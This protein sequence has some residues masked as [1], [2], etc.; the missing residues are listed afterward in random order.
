M[1][2]SMEDGNSFTN[3]FCN[4]VDIIESK[5]LDSA[6][7]QELVSQLFARVASNGDGTELKRL[8]EG[9]EGEKWIDIDYRD[10]EGST[11][12]ICASCFGH[13]HVAELLLGYGAS[14][15]TQDN[16]GWTA[17]MW[18]TSNQNEELVRILLEHGASSLAKSARGHTAMNIAASSN[19]S[20]GGSSD[21][22]SSGH[23]TPSV[24]STHEEEGTDPLRADG[25]SVGSPRSVL[26]A[27]R[28]T[29]SSTATSKRA[30]HARDS[31]AMSGHN[32]LSMLQASSGANSQSRSRDNY[33]Q[34]QQPLPTGDE[35]VTALAGK[36]RELANIDQHQ[37]QQFTK[38]G[39]LATSASSTGDADA[40]TENN[41]DEE[42]ES[43]HKQQPFD[44]DTLQ[45]DQMYVISPA[46]VP[47]FLHAV[48]KDIQP[49]N[50]LGPQISAPEHKFIPASMIFLA[51]R[52]AHH[53]GAPDFL[54][55]FL[56]DTI[57]SIIHGVQT[58][59]T[60]PISLAFWVSNMQTLLYYFKRDST[61]VKATSE[62]QGRISECMQDAYALLIRA[63]ER[64]IEPILDV[65]MLAYESMPDLFADVKFETERSQA[66]L[67][68]FF[69]GD[70]AASSATSG[71]S[72]GDLVTRKSSDGRPL[73]R[74]QTVLQKN[75][76]S[77]PRRGSLLS[78][79]APP[80][81]ASTTTSN[82]GSVTMKGEMP[83]WISAIERLKGYHQHPESPL[84]GSN[85]PRPSSGDTFVSSRRNSE[86]TTSRQSTSNNTALLFSNPCP[87]T[88]TYVIECLLDLLEMCEIHPKVVWGVM[89]Q[90]FCYLG[91]E[92]FN[93]VLTTRDFC[94]R[95]KAMHIRMNITQINDWLRTTS[96][97]LTVPQQQQQNNNDDRTPSPTAE[98]LLY[99]TY[100]NP[101]VELLEL[102]QCFSHLP[103]L[104]E[105]FEA[106]TK[107]P[108]L[109]ILQQ[110]TA[111]GNYRYEV[112]E[113]RISTDVAEYLHSVAKE[114]REGQ[115][116]DRDRK[117][118]IEKASRRSAAA[119]FSGGNTNNE[120]RTM[121]GRPG[122]FSFDLAT[123]TVRSSNS[124]NSSAGLVRFSADPASGGDNSLDAT[125]AFSTG[126]STG[127]DRPISIVSRD[128]AE[129]SGTLLPIHNSRPNG[130]GL[131]RS[132]TRTGGA[133]GRRGL[134]LPIARSG[135]SSRQSARSLFQSPST[136]M[137]IPAN[138]SAATS[139]TRLSDSL[140]PISETTA[141][142]TS[143][144]SR[145]RSR[146][147][148]DTTD[149]SNYTDQG[150]RLSNENMHSK[151]QMPEPP[152]TAPATNNNDNDGWTSP[153][154]QKQQQQPD[155]DCLTSSLRGPKGRHCRAEDM[156][157][158]M[159]ANELLSFAVPTS[160]EWLVWWQQLRH[161]PKE[162]KDGHGL[163]NET[164]VSEL[165][166]T[167]IKGKQ[168][169]ATECQELAPVVPTEILNVLSRIV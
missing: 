122:L 73:R 53:L 163:G 55:I 7:K 158:L 47:Q 91:N 30:P 150:E 138:S 127:A 109:N 108:S 115:R 142:S 80:T 141:G 114:V 105:F 90:M 64:D 86:A 84:S 14:V 139:T 72:G 154:P 146:T 153:P 67:S 113:K 5:E 40:K 97:R 87:R 58:H 147:T 145:Q 161:Q 144:S 168:S 9:C 52:F 46:T 132:A 57:A 37:Q 159:E 76:G 20:S 75:G 74:T 129:P 83:G 100:F 106:T 169:A 99:K 101:L 149:D 110:E 134:L 15:N 130:P 164:A 123:S 51:A 60:D 96:K 1:T 95:S 157:E 24:S 13:A 93:R 104:T 31:R 33:N 56:T 48:I 118:S 88:T 12:L 23:H 10:D 39:S 111:L 167:N 63:I 25:F 8:W 125:S 71:G 107:M 65:S 17:L 166:P 49:V 165:S 98:S 22:D 61:L 11:P 143:F 45:L 68:M 69:F 43:E 156:K 62:A 133:T 66:R 81:T 89:R 78:P 50:W 54:G 152:T 44:W 41:E 135:T 70:S 38:D 6:R 4:E 28:S 27:E 29:A 36:L 32:V 59:K 155:A 16:S 117:Q 136:T 85:G 128:G 140:E 120:R 77:R 82:S 92:M 26:S 151:Q 19:L 21:A 137:A 112:D 119:V 121:D 160:Q 94:C 126:P 18:A 102:L 116:A 131:T 42:D 148:V 79:K 2:A 34:Q 35:M 3:D 103:D 162:V 124:T